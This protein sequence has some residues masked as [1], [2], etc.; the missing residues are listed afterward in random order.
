[1]NGEPLDTSFEIIFPEIVEEDRDAYLKGLATGLSSGVITHRR[2]SQLYVDK[3][4]IRDYDYD[5]E[6]EERTVEDE[7]GVNP[8][9]L[10]MDALA[11]AGDTLPGENPPVGGAAEKLR[12]EKRTREP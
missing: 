3:M 1:M 11:A 7:A 9:A 5:T 10:R 4:R 12:Y 8:M 2:Y 6:Q